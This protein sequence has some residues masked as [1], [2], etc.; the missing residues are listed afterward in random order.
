MYFS[1]IDGT[2]VKSA[3]GIRAK[4][5]RIERDRTKKNGRRG[6]KRMVSLNNAR[7]TIATVVAG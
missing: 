4:E 2:I 1:A 3:A 7:L 6:R 5:K